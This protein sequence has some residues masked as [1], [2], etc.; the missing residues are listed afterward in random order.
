[1]LP[2]FVGILLVSVCFES[3]SGSVQSRINR[4]KTLEIKDAPYMAVVRIKVN[5]TVGGYCSGSILSDMLILTAGHCK[6]LF[7][8]MSLCNYWLTLSKTKICSTDVTC[9]YCV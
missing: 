6:S 5:A 7:I 2:I 1:M 9:T 4:G 3:G 8:Y